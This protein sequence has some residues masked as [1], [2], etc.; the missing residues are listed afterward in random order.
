M[1][2][3]DFE[4]IQTIQEEATKKLIKYINEN[5]KDDKYFDTV[6][7]YYPNFDEKK[8]KMAFTIWVSI[9]YRNNLGKSFIERML[10]E[11]P[12]ELSSKEKEILIERNKSFVSL[13]EV[14]DIKGY[15]VYV[16]DL[17]T[18]KEHVLSEPITS[19]ILN[20]EDLIFGRIGNIINFKGFIGN[21]SFLPKSAKAKFIDD[22]FIDYNRS[23]FKEPDLTIDK[24][25]KLYSINVYKIY[26]QCIYD[27]VE[28]DL[29]KKEDI[30]AILY[31][32]LDDFEYYLQNKLPKSEIKKHI[33]NLIN[34]F[35]HF[36][37]DYGTSLHDIIQ[38]DLE[39][40]VNKAIDEGFISSQQELSS[41]ISTLKKYL[42]YLKNM[43]PIYNEA[44]EKILKI[45][46]N[47]FLYINSEKS[48]MPIFE[49]NRIIS[50]NIS[51]LINEFAFDFIMDY[52]RF[53]LYMMSN[54]ISLTKKKKNIKRKNLLE[55]N[56]IMEMKENITKTA[57]N[58]EDFT[59]LEF[60]YHFSLN[61]GLSSIKGE[62]LFATN[63][64]KQFLRL[65]DE[66]KY[67]LF[68]QYILCDDFFYFNK[69]NIN[70]KTIISTR[71]DLI[72]SLSQFKEGLYYKY[73][74]LSSLKPFKYVQIYLKYFKLMKLIKYQYYPT[75]SFSVTSLGK[76]IFNLLSDENKSMDNGKIIYL[77]KYNNKG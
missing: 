12:Y 7:F 68:V 5:I 36:I 38:L 76:V 63:K 73:D 49:I 18:S 33:T 40:V 60:F 26:T 69:K 10:E 65:T 42:K 53:M 67:S 45:S 43:D 61:Y 46:K 9:D 14:K 62:K 50:N 11:K 59:L 64:S 74:K 54:P 15:K 72:K 25:L 48:K 55:L 58:Q 1:N 71:N 19:S 13:Y 44:Y 70:I 52:E 4:K 34:I 29:D 35:E 16:K 39:L 21:I 23:R 47:R 6:K 37:I 56:N 75:F 57:P 20:K 32:E 24:Y 17:L 31:D 22:I 27:A 3:L 28:K 51:N 41:Y 77:N 8:A 66:E 30:T 2:K